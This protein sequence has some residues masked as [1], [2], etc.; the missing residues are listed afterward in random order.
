MSVKKILMWVGVLGWL[1]SS[2]AAF[3]QAQEKVQS[4]EVFQ[5]IIQIPLGFQDGVVLHCQL[6]YLLK[7]LHR[8]NFL[9]GLAE[10]S[11]R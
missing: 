10:G 2:T 11:G 7:H 3:S 1:L 4:T 6:D 8:L 9:F 5:Q